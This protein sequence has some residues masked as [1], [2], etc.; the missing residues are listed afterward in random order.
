MR[1]TVLIFALLA[2]TAWAQAVLSTTPVGWQLTNV[3]G[4]NPTICKYNGVS[5]VDVTDLQS[6]GTAVA[7][8]AKYGGGT[9][10]NWAKGQSTRLQHLGFNAA[11]QYP[12]EYAAVYP[13]G[14]IPF[15]PTYGLSGYA[16]QDWAH[17]G[18]GAYRLKDIGYL[19]SPSGMKCGSSYGLGQEVDPYD[20]NA[21]TAFTDY[22]THDFISGWNFHNSIIVI[23]DEADFLAG[24]DQCCNP[25][26]AHP[27]YGLLIASSNPSVAHSA[28]NKSIDSI[29]GNPPF[30]TVAVSGGT[31]TYTGS[32]SSL[33]VCASNACVGL[34]FTFAGFSNGGNN[35]AVVATASTATTVVGTFVAQVNESGASAHATETYIYTDHSLYAKINLCNALQTEYGTVAAWNSAWGGTSFTTFGTSDAGGLTGIA[36]GTYNSWGTGT[37]CL[38]ENGTHLIVSG[39]NCSGTTGNGPQQNQAWSSPAQIQTDIDAALASLAGKYS[40]EV[41][42]GWNSA[43]G[44]FCPPVGIPVYDG[45]ANGSASVYAAMAAASPAPAFFWIAPTKYNT[46]GA[47]IGRVQSIINNDGGLPVIVANY[48]RATPD[49]FINTP[50]DSFAG[51]DCVSTQS[52][53]GSNYQTVDIGSLR[54][55]NPFGKYAV[56]GFEHWSLYDNQG[57]D[58]GLFTPNDNGY[59]GSQ[60]TTLSG[61]PAACLTNHAYTAPSQCTD[62]NG[63][64]ESLRV[65]S[66]SSAAS[67]TIWP[68]TST[69]NFQLQTV[70]GTCKWYDVSPNGAYPLVAEASNWGPSLGAIADSNATLTCDPP[71]T[72]SV[73]LTPLVAQ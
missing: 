18:I 11:G 50:C 6:E 43:C 64:Y 8:E 37:G 70:D 27:D 56:I 21:Q 28:A 47:F 10:V 24:I 38:D 62:S 71:A 52:S 7:V 53:R 25:N 33:A 12:Y 63:N 14:G 44:A 45:P 34:T 9:W 68:S 73:G 19:P 67:G 17:N 51:I 32:G 31:V 69:A 48:F 42:T 60:A 15:V 40:S 57:A 2:G 26:N 23:P 3:P 66:C 36:N 65:A 22:L 55:T 5:K 39:F 16:M 41:I 1:R 59:D 54:L 4:P 72:T 46:T 29:S 35:V 30:T 13:S 49:S 58:F 20:T 61:T